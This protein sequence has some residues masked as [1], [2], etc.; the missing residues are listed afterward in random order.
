MAKGALESSINT[1]SSSHISLTPIPPNTTNQSYSSSCST[2]HFLTSSTSWPSLTIWKFLP[3]SPQTKCSR[4]LSLKATASSQRF[5]HM[6]LQVWKP[7]KE[8][9]VLEPSNLPLS[10]KVSFFQF[11][12]LLMVCIYN[13]SYFL[14]NKTNCHFIFLI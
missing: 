4:P 1:S 5:C 2:V 6:P 9:E 12:S 11:Y 13:L 8:M 10:V 7:S 14:Y 3:Q